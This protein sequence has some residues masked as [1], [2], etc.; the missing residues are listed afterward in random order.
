MHICSANLKDN[1]QS[2]HN[3][4]SS[5][6]LDLIFPPCRFLICFLTIHF[7]SLSESGPQGATR[8]I[9]RG[10]LFSLIYMLHFHL[11]FIHP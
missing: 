7:L 9:T 2:Q 1:T 11:L 5:S 3:L 4:L 10:T 6:S 8:Q